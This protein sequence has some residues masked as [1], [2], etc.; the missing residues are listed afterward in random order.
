MQHGQLILSP[1]CSKP[2]ECGMEYGICCRFPRVVLA[3]YSLF[4][5]FLSEKAGTVLL[6]EILA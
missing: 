3:Y 6:R 1:P 4:E 5:V 2:G